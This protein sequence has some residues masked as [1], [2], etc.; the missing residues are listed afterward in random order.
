MTEYITLNMMKRGQLATVI[1]V[2]AKN[3]IKK[4]LYDIGIVPDT[5][6]RCIMKSPLGDPVAYLFR[7][8]VIA[9]RSE[10]SEGI[11]VKLIT[12]GGEENGID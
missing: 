4:R 11:L 7:E 5:K 3:E 1:E 8:A 12:E 2:N 6:I 10:D 9:L